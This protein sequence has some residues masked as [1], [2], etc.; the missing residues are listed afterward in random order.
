MSVQQV[1]T[2]AAKLLPEGS[3]LEEIYGPIREII[4]KVLNP[5]VVTPAAT[6]PPALSAVV[7]TGSIPG[8]GAAAPDSSTEG[9]PVD[10]DSS[11]LCSFPIA[12]LLP[13]TSVLGGNEST[14]GYYEFLDEEVEEG[15]DNEKLLLSEIEKFRVRQTRRDV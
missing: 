14:G 6:A 3:S 8:E 2:D 10:D 1:E 15:G 12:Y 4:Q 7:S 11:L 5:A 9:K 13:P